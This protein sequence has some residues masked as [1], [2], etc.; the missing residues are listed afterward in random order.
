MCKYIDEELKRD[1]THNGVEE[2]VKLVLEEGST[3]FDDVK[4]NLE[5]YK[6]LYDLIYGILIL[7]EEKK[8]T[9]DNPATEWGL[10]FGFIKGQNGKVVVA[11]RIFELRIANY[12]IEINSLEHYDKRVNG[13]LRQ[14]VIQ[15]GRFDMELTLRKF[16]EHYRQL[17]NADDAP[18]LER[19][20]RIV[21]LSYLQPL[22]NGRGFYHIE[23]QFTDLRRM[24]I[25]VDYGSQQFIIELKLWRGNAAHEEAYSQLAG[26]IKSKGA[27]EGYLLS[28][29]F[30]R[31]AHERELTAQWVEKDGVRIFDIM[32]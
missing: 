16:A 6:D 25:V 22:I 30:R 5:M 3:L 12:F 26:Y 8:Y 2:A 7:G 11:N 9:R 31:E 15:D 19:H 23:S 4:K 17:F 10:M 21:F 14:D 24:D 1:W 29:D 32:A 20:G 27:T 18:F 13:V 28:F